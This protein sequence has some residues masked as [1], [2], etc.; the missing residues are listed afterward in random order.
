MFSGTSLDVL[1][2]VLT[3]LGLFPACLVSNETFTFVREG[4]KKNMVHLM[5]GSKHISV[6]L[7]CVRNVRFHLILLSKAPLTVLLYKK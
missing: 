2:C 7:C 6:T 1:Q 4:I 5:Y 3:S